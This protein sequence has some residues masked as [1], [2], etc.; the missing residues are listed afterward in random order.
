VAAAVDVARASTEDRE[1]ALRSQINAA[2]QKI[3]A[4]A[5]DMEESLEQER[6][7]L[8]EVVKMEIRA[9]QQSGEALRE[10][11]EEGITKTVG[12]IGALEEQQTRA[13][14]RA[15]EVVKSFDAF[16]VDA[17]K[18]EQDLAVKI[19]RD[20]DTHI[21][22]EL[23]PVRSTTAATADGLAAVRKTVASHATD[24]TDLRKA[25]SE[26]SEE[27]EAIQKTLSAHTSD[28]SGLRSASK[29]A[30][31]DISDLKGAV[32][33]HSGELTGLHK[34]AAE[35]EEAVSALQSTVASHTS[36][37]SGLHSSVST[38]GSD[39]AALKQQTAA[40]VEALRSEGQQEANERRRAVSEL[41]RWFDQNQVDA[42]MAEEA[43]KLEIDDLS[44][45][46]ERRFADV[47]A[48]SERLHAR[49]VR[50]RQDHEALEALVK[51]HGDVFVD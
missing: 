13:I 22:T 28:L 12:R 42:K 2:L 23:A 45:A 11:L 24:L 27:V 51:V 48:E 14:H 37:L 40:E 43:L 4:Y 7:R 5:R 20:A 19:L 21:E 18:R 3:R 39:L 15:E 33:G 10:A 38:L 34:T 30:A 50:E 41:K 32:S 25:A 46:V 49:M 6:I 44:G 8:E 17:A 31:Q 35:A 16:K 47:Q 9:R 36:D 1:A 26:A 29:T